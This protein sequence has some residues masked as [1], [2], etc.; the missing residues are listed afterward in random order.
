MLIDWF[1]VVAQLANFAILVW[2]LKRFLYH[3]VLEAMAAREKRVRETVAAADRQKAAAE[4]QTK[5][6]REQQETFAQQKEELLDSARREAAA[7]RDE[8]LAQARQAADATEGQR[9]MAL[10]RDWQEFRAELTQRTQGE[11]LAVARQAL[12]ELADS[13]IEERMAEAFLKKF[14]GLDGE[15]EGAA[16]GR[17]AQLGPPAHRAQSL[18]ASTRRSRADST[19]V[20]RATGAGERGSV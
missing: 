2:L 11:A 3:P 20:A 1:T 16:P 18:R 5:C 6:L 17:G 10:D 14:I 9:R 8:L 13:G 4:E 15:V 19:D 12:R 7:A